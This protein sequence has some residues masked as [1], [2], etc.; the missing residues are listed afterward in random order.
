M[1]GFWFIL[2]LRHGHSHRHTAQE[3]ILPKSKVGYQNLDVPPL[4][5]N[6]GPCPPKES[7]P[8]PVLNQQ[9]YLIYVDFL[10]TGK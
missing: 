1:I 10:L 4:V 6:L 5:L 9:R 8:T 7:A 3:N 2:Y